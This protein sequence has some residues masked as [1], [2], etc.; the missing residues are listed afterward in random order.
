MIELLAATFNK[1]KLKEIESLVAESR[2]PLKLLALP[3]FNI[4]ERC[5]EKGS[6]FMENA[7]AKSLFYGRFK[8]DIYTIGEDSGLEVEALN[9]APGIHSARFSGHDSTDEKNIHKLLHQLKTIG[10][11]RAKFIT[12]LCLS[13]NGTIIKTFIGEVTGTILH[14]LRGTNGFGYDP[15]F[16]YPLLK[17]TFAEISTEMKN[18]ISHR[19]RA[20]SQLIEYFEEL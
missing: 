4:T 10:N 19:A 3:D 15:V 7:E 13:R 9:G 14:D 11:R 12:A 6:T 17:K 8:P 2:V 5:P 18:R 16:Y 20:F 1:G